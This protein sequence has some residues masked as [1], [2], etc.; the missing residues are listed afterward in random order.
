[1]ILDYNYMFDGSPAATNGVVAGVAISTAGGSNQNSTN[2]IDLLNARDMGIGGGIDLKIMVLVTAAF[3]STG[4]GTLQVKAQGSTDNVTYTTYAET[5]AI[6]SGTLTAGV[7]IA[8]FDWPGIL[9]DTGAL[10]R[11]LRL[12]YAVGVSTFSAGSV[13]AGLVLGR[14]D[15]RGYPSGITISN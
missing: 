15:N 14:D 6:A 7:K 3:T 4:A 1:M 5:P 12:Q 9:P 8:Q 13:I 10:P 2:V 11:Y